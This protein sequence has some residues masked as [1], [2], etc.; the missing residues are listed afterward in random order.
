VT[1]PATATLDDLLTMAGAADAIGRQQST[2]S[3]AIDAGTLPHVVTA[4]GRAKLIR[5]ADLDHWLATMSRG[6]PRG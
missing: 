6:R 3:R 2:I 1:A 5:R 4:D